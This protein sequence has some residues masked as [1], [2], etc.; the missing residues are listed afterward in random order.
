MVDRAARNQLAARLRHLASGLMSNERFEDSSRR[1]K[2]RAIA[3]LE[4]RLAWPVYDDM[5]EHRLTGE[6]ALTYGMR[7]D[8]ARAVLFLK[9]E[10]EYEWATKR[11]LRGFI[12]S[13]FRLRPLRR[14]P[15]V[16]T[17][18]GDLR[19]WPF[20]RRAD[21]LAALKTRPYFHGHE[22]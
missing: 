22:V 3:E 1:S 17:Q 4:W 6:Y 15:P 18:G 10:F 8:F 12:N 7:R 13:T 5:H 21:Y 9:T 16:S 14:I 11:G 19:V 20:Y 2:D